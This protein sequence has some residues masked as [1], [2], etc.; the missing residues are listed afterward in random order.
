MVVS[1]P[2]LIVMAP[3]AGMPSVDSGVPTA[4]DAVPVPTAGAAE[5]LEPAEDWEP[6]ED[7]EPVPLDAVEFPDSTC[8]ISAVSSELTR[9]KAVPLAIAAKP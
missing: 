3:P 2:E 7:E 5:D 8:C 4:S 6:A 1:P 9:F